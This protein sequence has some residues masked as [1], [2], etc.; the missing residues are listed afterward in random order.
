MVAAFG[1]FL[2]MYLTPPV[3]YSI[4]I[5]TDDAVAVESLQ[6]GAL[7]ALSDPDYYNRVKQEFIAKG[8]SFIDA[9]LSRM[10]LLVYQSGTTTLDV[11][12]LTKG[13][14]GSWWETPAG[15]YQIQTKEK[16][17]F[18]SFG[19]TYQPWS[20]AFQG[21]FFIHGWPHYED[22]TPVASMYSGGC[23]RLSTEDAKKVYD[24]VKVGMP[25]IIYNEKPVGDSF[26]YQLK[27]P[28]ISASQYLVADFAN[29]TVLVSK[30]ASSTATIA[31]ITKLVTALVATEYIN[32]DKE[33]SVPREAIIYTS[34]PRLR[35]GQNI[36]AYDLI[37]LLLQESSNEAAEVL[38]S[39]RGRRQF[40]EY[41]NRKSRA[42]GLE[43]TLFTDPSG[44]KSDLSTPED[45]FKL[46]RYIYDNRRFVLGITSNSLTDSA[47][48]RPAFKN[49]QNFN[50]IKN[51]G[52]KL[53]GGKVG[54]TNEAGETYAGVFALDIG[55][56]ER[57]IAVIVLG[58][59]DVQSD[60]KKLLQFVHASYAPAE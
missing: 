15:I 16:S 39:E 52:A 47:Y 30:D 57:Q 31:S 9:D 11:P 41:M 50:T 14:P 43:R 38:A 24:L 44:A 46:L 48:G 40:V 26:N 12:I 8:A 51:S 5:P 22:G 35:V 36:R 29:G 7:S 45:L 56:S 33:I 55:D 19:H 28:S 3:V 2:Y 1:A 53:L 37:F 17:H 18:S 42:I 6:Y 60:V 21:N 23:I 49:I 34:V 4:S 10:R 27:A 13:K 58:S 32:L 59:K 20:L 25:V 54:E